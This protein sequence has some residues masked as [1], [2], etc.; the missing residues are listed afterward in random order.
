M[1]TGASFAEVVLRHTL[2]YRVEQVFL[3]H[4]E[5]GLL[6]HHLTAQSIAA[7]APDMVAGMLTAIQDFARDSFQVAQESN[8]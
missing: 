3:V 8:T 7:Q 2:L 1:R 5:S 4:R 6:L